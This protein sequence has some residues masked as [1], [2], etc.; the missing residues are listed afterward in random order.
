MII[1]NISKIKNLNKILFNILRENS[2]SMES[3]KLAN[4]GTYRPE[5]KDWFYMITSEK[6]G[7]PEEK[8][9]EFHHKYIDI[10]MVISG[11]EDIYYSLN[12]ID[13]M[14]IIEKGP[15]LFFLPN[16]DNNQKV[17]LFEGDFAVFFPNEVHKP[18]CIG[19]KTSDVIKKVV[20]KI[21][22]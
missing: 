13:K 8:I 17:T 18:M 14:D 19:E 2:L 11:C 5:N 16:H 3:L 6:P 4:T 10:Q 15:D 12:E 21:P 7:K 9:A 20:V 22:V 1:G